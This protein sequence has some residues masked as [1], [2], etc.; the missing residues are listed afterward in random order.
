M[1]MSLPVEVFRFDE[2][3]TIENTSIVTS[4]IFHVTHNGDIILIYPYATSSRE[5]RGNRERERE[6]GESVS[7]RRM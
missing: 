6:I 5:L 7:W 2:N 1:C 4:L 3:E